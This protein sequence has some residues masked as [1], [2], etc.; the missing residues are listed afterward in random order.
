MRM[1][2]DG[3][4]LLNR[5]LINVGW[6]DQRGASAGSQ[7]DNN[8]VQ[9]RIRTCTV[10]LIRMRLIIIQPFFAACAGLAMY[11]PSSSNSGVGVRWQGM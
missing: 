7:S 9:S 10:Y 5:C 1:R 11:V 4:S 3:E 2:L 8:N 6:G